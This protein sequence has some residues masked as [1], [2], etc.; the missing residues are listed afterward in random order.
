MPEGRPLTAEPGEDSAEGT[1]ATVVVDAVGLQERVVAIPVEEARYRSLRAVRGGLVW[2][3]DPIAGVLGEGGADLDEDRPRPALQRFDLRKREVKELVGALDW[4]RVS[5]DGTRLVV[6][7]RDE[8]RVLPSSRKQDD[9]GD[10][11]TV[12]TS[13]ARFEADPAALWRHAYAEAGRFV[14]RD[15]WVPDMSGVDWDGVLEQ[16][17]PL[18]TR[19]RGSADFAD[20]LWDLFGELGT[21]H[22]YVNGAGSAAGKYPPAGHL[23]ADISRDGAGRWVVDRVLPGESSDPRARSPLAAPGVAVGPGDELVAVD[24]RPVDP[25]RGPWPLLA[26]TRWPATG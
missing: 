2:L 4:F 21:S 15:F 1:A 7:D 9:A 14:R 20:L 25:L 16:Y 17:R 23:G 19:I 8:L 22:A 6:R 5:G 12:D 3:R 26:S 11:V 24:G 13:R 18:L 10:V